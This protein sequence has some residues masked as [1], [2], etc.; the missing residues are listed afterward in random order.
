MEI[1][2]RCVRATVFSQMY[3]VLCPEGLEMWV[4]MEE[5][6]EVKDCFYKMCRSSLLDIQILLFP[7]LERASIQNTLRIPI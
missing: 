6:G 2:Y 1:A 3:S 4:K 5:E 7:F